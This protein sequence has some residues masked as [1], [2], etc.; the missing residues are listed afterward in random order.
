MSCGLYHC[1]TTVASYPQMLDDDALGNVL[2]QI[3]WLKQWSTHWWLRKDR[4]TSMNASL[5]KAVT[6]FL[7]N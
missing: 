3:P 1:A 4:L 6:C 7:R 5:Q 2:Q